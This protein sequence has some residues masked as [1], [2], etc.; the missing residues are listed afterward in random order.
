MPRYAPS[1]AKALEVLLW[2][3]NEEPGIDVYHAVKSLFFADKRHVAEYGR[4]IVG[5]DYIADAWGPLPQ[6]LYRLIRRDPLEML[7][8]ATN[9]PLPFTI[10]DAHRIYASREAN[11]RLLSPSDVEALRYGHAHVRGRS[12]DD[13]F[14]ET[15]ADPAYL[16]ADGGRMDYRDFIPEDDPH[17]EEKA[18]DLSEVA[19]FA[20]L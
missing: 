18:A 10:D 3:A 11:S 20:V 5:D 14:N 16:N 15:H 2:L 13:I 4:P 19:P 8:L 7:A 9:G 6:V 17:R 12:F 1:A